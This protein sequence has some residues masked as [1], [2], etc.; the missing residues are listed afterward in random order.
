MKNTK[1]AHITNL[2]KK[3]KNKRKGKT[4]GTKFFS[5]LYVYTKTLKISKIC[6]STRIKGNARYK[7]KGKAIYTRR[8]P[9]SIDSTIHQL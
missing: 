5:L 2:A 9:L 8:L 1:I 6:I 4:K 7:L 3:K